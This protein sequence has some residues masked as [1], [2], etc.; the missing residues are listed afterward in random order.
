MSSFT[1]KFKHCSNGQEMAEFAVD[2]LYE[3][4]GALKHLSAVMMQE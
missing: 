4:V 3:A 1:A 2:A